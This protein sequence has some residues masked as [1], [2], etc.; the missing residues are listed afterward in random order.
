MHG[1]SAFIRN[2]KGTLATAFALL[3]VPLSL[4]IALMIDYS[5]TMR[6]RDAMRNTADTAAL[7][8][9]N[10]A[11]AILSRA[12]FNDEATRTAAAT[13]ADTAAKNV[14]ASNGSTAGVTPPVPTV[15]M[16]AATSQ[17]TVT[18]DY[19]YSSKS[20]LS[21]F[22]TSTGTRI[23]GQSTAIYSFPPYIDI[24]VL[25]DISGSMG[26]GATRASQ[27]QMRNDSSISCVF[28]CHNNGSDK[29]TKAKSKGY[30]MRIDV[31]RE[32]LTRMVDTAI[33]E[34]ALQATPTVRIGLYSFSNEYSKIADASYDLSTIKTKAQSITLANWGGGTDFYN[35]MAKLNT[36][37]TRVGDGSGS[38]EPRAFVFI[39]SDGVEDGAQGTGGGWYWDPD[40][41]MPKT[42][43]WGVRPL[44]KSYCQAFKSRGITVSALYTTYVTF[45]PLIS[46]PWDAAREN[47]LNASVIPNIPN[48]LRDCSSGTGNFFQAD[49]PE[50]I[51]NAIQLMFSNATAPLRLAR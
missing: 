47:Y 39:I 45:D 2:D 43:H 6:S 7:A 30:Q 27:I 8:G 5:T 15:A 37:I 25:L 17:I 48:A 42:A 11:G 50:D 28:G 31:L 12:M 49:R 22:F 16:V 9:A 18:V 44:P 19:N 46:D 51:D 24:H 3:S 29:Y 13:A 34:S 4:S 40:N 32:S 41:P 21:H 20:A 35:A 36:D 1:L 33:N 26:L 14:F 38:S 23:A 10:A